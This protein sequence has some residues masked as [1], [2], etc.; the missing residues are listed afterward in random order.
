MAEYQRK[1]DKAT[2]PSVTAD[3]DRILAGNPFTLK[4]VDERHRTV[5]P[6]PI[7]E[8]ECWELPA[9]GWEKRGVPARG[10]VLFFW[11]HPEYAVRSRMWQYQIRQESAVSRF[12]REVFDDPRE[13]K[14]LA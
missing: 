8:R 4:D 10:G 14:D 12:N 9:P 7:D 6:G 3:H 1:V 13:R 5:I 11:F 2:K